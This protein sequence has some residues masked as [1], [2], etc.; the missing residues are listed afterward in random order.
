MAVIVFGLVYLLYALFGPEGARGVWAKNQTLLGLGM[1][2]VGVLIAAGFTIV[3]FRDIEQ[4]QDAQIVK[5]VE[6]IYNQILTTDSSSF[7][8]LK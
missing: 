1:I 3:A 2:L 8:L 6:N 7:D 5:W 4:L